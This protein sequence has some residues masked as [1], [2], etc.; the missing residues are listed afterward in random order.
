MAKR[1]TY[2]PVADGEGFAAWVRR[3]RGRSGVYVIRTLRGRALYVGES[4]TGRLYETLTR[5]FQRWGGKTSGPTYSRSAVKVGVRV[6][7]PSS[8]V[9]AQNRLIRR[10]S[11]EDNT[12]GKGSKNIPF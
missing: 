9:A 1:V 4:H 3:L 6:C 2:R 12:I 11:P 7:P 5:H 10:L 8:A